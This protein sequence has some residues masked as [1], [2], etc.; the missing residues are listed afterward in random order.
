VPHQQKGFPTLG[1]GSAASSNLSSLTLASD[2]TTVSVS[3][4]ASNEYERMAHYNGITG[5]GDH[6]ALV[7]RSDFDTTPFPKPVGRY[8]HI[9][10]KSVCEVYNTSPNAACDDVGPKICD[11]ITKRNISY[12]SIDP[13]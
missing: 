6:P 7:Y 5:D 8:G 3:E 9:P 4:C 13:A 2:T 11:L 12:S 1:L 10:V